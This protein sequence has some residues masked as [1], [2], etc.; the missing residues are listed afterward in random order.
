MQ[1]TGVPAHVAVLA[2]IAEVNS[3]LKEMPG[4]MMDKFSVV[5]DE[6]GV[7]AGN[8]TSNQI[9]NLI[10]SG[11]HSVLHNHPMLQHVGQ[12]ENREDNAGDRNNSHTAYNWKGKF[13]YLPEGYR[14][15]DVPLLQG[16]MIWWEGNKESAI[17]PLSI[18]TPSDFNDKNMRKRY[19]DWKTIMNR[20]QEELRAIGQWKARQT[21][22]KLIEMCES[23]AASLPQNKKDKSNRPNEWK[24]IT[25]TKE[26]RLALKRNRDEE[27]RQER[28]RHVRQR[29]QEVSPS[30]TPTVLCINNS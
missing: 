13:H 6:K 22:Q 27:K 11:I 26:L 3:T 12:L 14:L 28:D 4:D 16:W 19:S 2:S 17:P 9:T 10:T 30:V 24:V 25:A 23:A 15:P 18:V 20:M 5:L 21:T 29:T 7:A 1:S 8:L